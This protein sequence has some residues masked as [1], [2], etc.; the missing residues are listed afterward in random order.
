[1]LLQIFE[2]ISTNL[3]LQLCDKISVQDDG[4]FKQIHDLGRSIYIVIVSVTPLVLRQQE[5]QIVQ[6]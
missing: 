3:L 5:Q 1:M 6:C 4:G 2:Y